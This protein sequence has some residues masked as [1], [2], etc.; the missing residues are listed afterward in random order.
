MAKTYTCLD[1][2]VDCTWSTSG[3][4]EDEVV[5]N[6]GEHAAEV[7]PDVELT[8]ELMAAVRGVIKDA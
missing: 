3:E 8:P 5:T 4:T 2:G 1:V 6:I 7:H